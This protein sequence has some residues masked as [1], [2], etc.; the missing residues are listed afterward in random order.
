MGNRPLFPDLG[1]LYSLGFKAIFY[2]YNI[3]VKEHVQLTVITISPSLGLGHSSWGGQGPILQTNSNVPD[4][5]LFGGRSHWTITEL[6][7]FKNFPP[8]YQ[9]GIAMFEPQPRRGLWLKLSIIS[10]SVLYLE[11][12]NVWILILGN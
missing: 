4:L 12:K 7:S 8:E 3:L 1:L 10:T 2:G 6:A 5:L 11:V 9:T